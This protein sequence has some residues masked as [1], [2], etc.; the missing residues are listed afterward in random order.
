MHE[1]IIV[2]GAGVGGLTA[3]ALLSQRGFDVTVL[4]AHVEPGG[5]AATFFHQ[6]YR[7]DAGAT[8]VG[9]FQL[10]GPHD[11]VA[12][13]L[14]IEWPIRSIDPAMLVHLPDRLIT[15]YSDAG[16]WREER[17]RA[18]GGST[19]KFWAEQERAA[20]AVWNLAARIPSWPISSIQDAFGLIPA[21]RPELILAAPLAFTNMQA[22]SQ[23]LGATDRTFKTYLDAQLLI[24]AQAIAADTNALYGAA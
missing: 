15:C 8:L 21:V 18:F 12:R 2:V 1:K 6:G 5:C 10:N 4:E 9:G 24:S 11:L 22:W 3:A 7:F 19:E 16:R 13:E 23:R 20:N 14:G 17:L